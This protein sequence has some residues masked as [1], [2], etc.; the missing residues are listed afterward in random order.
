LTPAAAAN[1]EE[2]RKNGEQ[3][4]KKKR[5][6]NE[7]D[8]KKKKKKKELVVKGCDSKECGETHRAPP[9]PWPSCRLHAH[10]ASKQTDTLRLTVENSIGL[11]EKKN[12]FFFFL[13]FLDN[14]LVH[15]TRTSRRVTVRYLQQ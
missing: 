9:L 1:R 13:V 12:F 5:E 10:Q 2:R 15:R 6:K 14:S 8:Q 7:D 11:E 4:E 3:C